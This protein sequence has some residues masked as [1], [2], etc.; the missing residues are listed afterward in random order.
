MCGP[1]LHDNF[2]PT[3]SSEILALL[4]VTQMCVHRLCAILRGAVSRLLRDMNERVYAA[5][6]LKRLNIFLE[7]LIRFR[8]ASL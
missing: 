5:A 6:V 7:T 8:R 1:R 4:C 3:P 2:F